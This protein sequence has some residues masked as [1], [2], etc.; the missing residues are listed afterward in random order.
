MP[1]L[2]TIREGLAVHQPRLAKLSGGIAVE[3]AVAVIIHEPAGAPPELLL[4][5]RAQSERDPWS[6]QMAFPGGRYDSRDRDLEATATRET[7]EEI[8][9]QLA[10]P[11]G[12]LDDATGGRPPDQHVLVASYVY[13]LPQRPELRPNHE[14]SSAVWIPLPWILDPQSAARYQFEREEFRGSYPALRYGPYTVWGLTYRILDNFVKIVGRS[15]P[16]H[17]GQEIG[18]QESD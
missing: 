17:Q 4:I 7:L 18:K 8:G 16:S 15:L 13:E 11:L 2:A 12:R 6:G 1:K 14:V 3:A 9:V 10:R 5:E